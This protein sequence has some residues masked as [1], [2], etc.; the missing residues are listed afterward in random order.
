MPGVK[1][2]INK[3][4]ADLKLATKSVGDDETLDPAVY[5]THQCAE[6]SLK[7]FLVFIGKKIPK[8]HDLS[9]LLED[10]IKFDS[11][12]VLLQRECKALDPY[13]FS[14]RY[15]NDTFCVNQQDLVE[16]LAMASK[17]FHFMKNK[18]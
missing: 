15:P 18:V 4:L 13:G 2:W 11:A 3:A 6:K 14:S 16:A 5:L 9:V 8:T 10:C 12:F 17:I 1:D 7:T